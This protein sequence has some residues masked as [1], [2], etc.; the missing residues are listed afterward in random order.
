[1]EHHVIATSVAIREICPLPGFKI[2]AELAF[3]VF[4]VCHHFFDTDVEGGI[5]GITARNALEPNSRA[6]RICTFDSR[7]DIDMRKHTVRQNLLKSKG[8]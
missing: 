1:M 8:L 5:G 3:T 6:A 4:R 7:L 2:Q